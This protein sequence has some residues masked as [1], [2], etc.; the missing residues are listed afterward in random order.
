MFES[1]GGGHI[2]GTAFA[3]KFWKQLAEFSVRCFGIEKKTL[4]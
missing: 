4:R 2:M 3:A 1:N